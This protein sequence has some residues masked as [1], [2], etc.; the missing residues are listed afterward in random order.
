MV[1]EKEIHDLIPGSKT[2][3]RSFAEYIA[4]LF[5]DKFIEIY[6]GDAY[7]EVSFEQTSQQYPAVFCGKVV[8][9]YKECLIISAAYYNITRKNVQLGKFMFIS[10][11]AIRSL[12]EVNGKGTLEDMFFRSKETLKIKELIDNG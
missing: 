9:A 3:G 11:R 7:E 10:E 1:T 12:A 2:A 4:E 8:G 5:K 6:V